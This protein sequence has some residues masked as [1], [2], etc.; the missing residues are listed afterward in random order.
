MPKITSKEVFKSQVIEFQ[1]KFRTTERKKL[2]KT[3]PLTKNLKNLTV[4][5]L[6]Q[7]LQDA[8]KILQGLN[9]DHQFCDTTPKRKLLNLMA[10]IRGEILLKI[11]E[12]P[13]GKPSREEFIKQYLK[14]NKNEVSQ[15]NLDFLFNPETRAPMSP[16][17]HLIING[18][19]SPDKSEHVHITRHQRRENT[20]NKHSIR[21]GRQYASR[22]WT[23]MVGTLVLLPLAPLLIPA[24]Y[25]AGRIVGKAEY[26]TE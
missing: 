10:C 21:K 26:S 19:K 18:Y 6:V 2:T 1:N 15:L 14:S 13:S 23:P 22:L 24:V 25:F 3:R 9:K 16:T 11:N 17:G 20:S 5:K 8:N 12:D 4:E 7:H